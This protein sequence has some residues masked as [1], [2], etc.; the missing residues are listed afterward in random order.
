[1]TPDGAVALILAS[2]VVLGWARLAW[3]YR[4]GGTSAAWRMAALILLQPVVAG[5][6]YATLLPPRGARG[7]ETLVVATAGAP[8]VVATGPGERLVA[9]PEAGRVVGAATAPDLGTALRRAGSV[10]RVRIV[11]SGLEAR[12]RDAAA[13]VSL[14]FDPPSPGLGL[15]A[16]VP[17]AT[18]Q[19]GAPFTVAARSQGMSGTAELVDPAGRV[20][21]ARPIGA[22]GAIALSGTARH[23]GPALFSLRLRH[24]GGVIERADV[25]LWVE[26]QPAARVL[27]LA[28]APGPEVKFLRRWATDAGLAPR[29]RAEVGG[30]LGLGD[31]V[32]PGAA[33]LAATDV[34]IV[35]DRRWAEL[36]AAGRGTVVSAVRAGM[37][38][39]VRITGPI[40]RG[41][42]AAGLSVAAGGDVA[43]VALAPV[44]PSDE[45][46]VAR[47]GTGT[48]DRPTSAAGARDAVPVLTRQVATI[49]GRQAVPLLRDARGAVFAGWQA[50]GRGRVAA[51]GLHDSF[52]LVTSGHGDRFADLWSSLVSAVA[53][54]RNGAEATI[55]PLPRVGERTTICE[56]GNARVVPKGGEA[57][58]LVADPG[59]PGCAGYW[60]PFSG[61]HRLTGAAARAFFVHATGSMP[62]VLAAER[63]EATRRMVGERRAIRSERPSERGSSWPWFAGFLVA[64]AL[65]WWFERASMGRGRLPA[66]GADVG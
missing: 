22:G 10:A 16:L 21:D 13:G 51:I 23:A 9:L 46:L 5:L 17:P 50:S 3:W 59:T 25:P 54:P 64:A 61:W 6:L 2:A 8:R 7:S 29:V 24:G 35:D 4:R 58:P 45:A 12:D 65:L 20:V 27:I 1:M 30:G 48:R 49:G 56:A 42:Q 11:G 28:G 32:T 60:P 19:P 47:R 33:T 18:A 63:T 41:W 37:G 55:D 43:P 39:V 53:R 66:Q 36:G 40:P 34:L 44:A 52:A 14:G 57:I 38:L 26:A 15:V 31:P 62:G